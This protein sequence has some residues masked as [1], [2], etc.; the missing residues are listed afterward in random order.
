MKPP[1][2]EGAVLAAVAS[3]AGGGVW[4][5]LGPVASLYARGAVLILGLTCCYLLY[6]FRRSGARAGR[7]FSLLAVGGF[8]LGVGWCTPSLAWVA[9]IALGFIWLVRA[10]L[11]HSTLVA[12]AADLGLTTLSYL[13]GLW[14]AINTHNVFLIIWCV[15]LGHAAFVAIPGHIAPP[16]AA[17][18]NPDSFKHAQ[19]AAEAA[20][21]AL[22]RST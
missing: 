20:L 13:A 4:T 12:A 7:V 1:F 21:R 3:V 5:L 18:A 11:F 15:L 17:R 9:A 16:R 6:L 22:S 19:R 8:A 14:A 2:L 10:L